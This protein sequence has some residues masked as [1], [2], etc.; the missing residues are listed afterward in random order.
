MKRILFAI[1]ILLFTALSA[2]AQKQ[3][4]IEAGSGI[5][6]LHMGF[7]GVAPS[8]SKKYELAEMGQEAVVS[9]YCPSAILS[10]VMRYSEHWELVLTGQ[11]AW[12]N[13]NLVQYEQF[14]ID[15]Y[16]KPRYNL[17]K[18]EDL[19]Q[20]SGFPVAS[21]TV[22]WRCLW[23][24]HRKIMFYTG[25][26]VGISAGTYFYPA[27]SITP[28]GM[29]VCGNHFYA[30]LETPIGPYATFAAGGLGWTF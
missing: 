10:G 20:R 26:G 5:Q 2:S 17:G 11:L 16:G 9:D 18:K 19:G 28:V 4:R 21:G 27:P 22:Q 24:P 12:R 25:R 3:W 29:R 15:P 1:T 14:G 30:F 7:P 8:D 13:Y 6:P 23:N